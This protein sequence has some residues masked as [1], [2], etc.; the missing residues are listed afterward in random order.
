MKPIIKLVFTCLLI[1]IYSK[2]NAQKQPY[3]ISAHTG[4]YTELTDG[5][6]ID[7]GATWNS[8]TFLDLPIGF[9]FK[10]YGI[11]TTHILIYSFGIGN[12]QPFW[13]IFNLSGNSSASDQGINDGSGIA[14]SPR[15]YLLTG[16]PG[17][18]ILKIQYKNIAFDGAPDDYAN[19]QVWLYE[20]SNKIDVIVGP[21]RITQP[22]VVYKGAQG[23]L[24]G[25]TILTN[26]DFIDIKYANILKGDPSSPGSGT[27]AKASDLPTLSSTPANGQIYTFDPLTTGINDQSYDPTVSI[28]PNPANEN[29]HIFLDNSFAHASM[30]VDI[31]DLTGKLILSENEIYKKELNINVSTLAKGMYFYRLIGLSP[32]GKSDIKTGKVMIE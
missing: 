28:Y 19:Y 20:T 24:I 10:Y 9:T 1:S 27:S 26:S 23:P 8:G 16:T 31:F 14:K 30:S 17:S 6:S 21:N 7:S 5:I 22:T 12:V 13:H 25:V 29:L 15:S 32:E 2:I 3:T 18:R 11:N 4:T